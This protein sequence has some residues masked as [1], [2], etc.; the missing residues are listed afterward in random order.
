MIGDTE[1]KVSVSQMVAG[2][3]EGDRSESLPCSWEADAKTASN[4]SAGDGGITCVSA[5]EV[6]S[7]RNR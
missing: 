7:V 6:S 1:G 5:V 4:E 3:G 2:R